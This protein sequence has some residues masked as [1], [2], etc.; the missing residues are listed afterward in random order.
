MHMIGRA[1]GDSIDVAGLLFKHHT[2]VFV[3]ARLRKGLKRAGGTP[4]VNVA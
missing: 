2:K 4:L 3:A 1:D